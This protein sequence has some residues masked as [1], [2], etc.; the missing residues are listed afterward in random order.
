MLSLAI[1]AAMVALCGG[2]LAQPAPTLKVGDPA[3][4]LK[5]EK[6]VKGEAITGFEKE[7]VYVVEFWA[8]WCGPCRASIPHLTHLQKQYKDKGVTVVGIS[9]SEQKGLSDVEPFVKK[10]G[11]RMDYTVAWDDQGATSTAWMDAAGQHGIPTAFV[12]DQKSTIAW[13][14]H[15]LAGLDKVVKRV[16]ARTWDPKLYEKGRAIEEKLEQAFEQDKADEALRLIDEI[17]ALDAELFGN[18]TAAKFQILL[19]E[20]KDVKGAY[21][22]IARHVATTLKDEADTLNA[23]AW[24]ILDMPGLPER[25][26]PLAMRAATRAVEVTKGENAMI[27]DTLARAYFETGDVDKAIDTQTKAIAAETDEDAKQEYAEALNRYKEAKAKGT[28]KGG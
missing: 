2:V 22:Y 23:I 20:K 27:L 26:L 19:S 25:D 17:V 5:I 14:G 7:R 3:P 18:Y 10:M 21:D 6:W 15:P 1:P 13:I 12:V 16:T 9:S 24:T 28:K 8:T 11:A 4:A